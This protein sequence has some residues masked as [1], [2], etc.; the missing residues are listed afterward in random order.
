MNYNYRYCNEVSQVISNDIASSTVHIFSSKQEQEIVSERTSALSS[1]IKEPLIAESKTL[2]S[3]NH[4][5][6]TNKF[7]DK[8]AV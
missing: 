1:L 6:I 8:Y 4:F 3:T 5:K 7:N 2:G